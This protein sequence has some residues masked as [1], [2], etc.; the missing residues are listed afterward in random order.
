MSRFLRAIWLIITAPLRFIAWLGRSM[1]KLARAL[2]TFFTQEETEEPS[3][4]VESIQKAIENP[5]SLVEH[6]EALR[7]HL[8][9]S[10]VFLLITT[11]L[12]FVLVRQMMAF[13]ARPLEGGLETLKAIEVTENI[14]VVMR[15]ALLG[16]FALAFPYFAFEIWLFIAPGLKPAA[17]LPSLLALPTAFLLFLGGM[18]FAF[19]GMLPV[20]LPFLFNFMGLST[21]ARPYSYFSFVT[22]ILFWIGIAFEFPLLAFLLARLGIL[23]ARALASQWRLAIVIIAVLAAAITP[24]VDPINMG[25][26]MAPMTVLYFLSILLARLAE[27][28]RRQSQST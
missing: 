17:R 14:G 16:G 25:L 1:A 2:H 23:K 7:K 3:D 6:I 4:L 8:L 27:G 10:V 19:Y 13:L 5:Q 28:I 20:A 26:V 15:V 9:R 21:E 11:A 12:S 18:A 22:G 24:T